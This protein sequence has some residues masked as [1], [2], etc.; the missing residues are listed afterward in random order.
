ML[1][2]CLD[3]MWRFVSTNA[4][5]NYVIIKDDVVVDLVDIDIVR[6]PKPPF[7]SRFFTSLAFQIFRVG[8]T[9]VS[10]T[11]NHG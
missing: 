9:T 3:L 11:R 7:V 10:V 2:R 5:N 6:E 8:K 1:L 4:M